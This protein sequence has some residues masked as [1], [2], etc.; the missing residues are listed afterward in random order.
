ALPGPAAAKVPPGRIAL[1]DAPDSRGRTAVGCGAHGFFGR[2]GGHQSDGQGLDAAP[3]PGPDRG[4]EQAARGMAR[5]VDEAPPGPG[6]AASWTAAAHG[7]LGV[8]GAHP[9]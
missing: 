3:A 1:T 5:D 9:V 7:G 2:H 4:A 6:L 8:A